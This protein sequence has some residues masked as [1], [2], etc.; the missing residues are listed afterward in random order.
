MQGWNSLFAPKGTPQ[1]VIAKLNAALRK[2]VANDGYLKRLDELGSLPPSDEEMSP[3]YVRQFIPTEI[4]KFRKLL[5]EA[6]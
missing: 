6:K 3:D 1:P 2:G 4:E 5:S